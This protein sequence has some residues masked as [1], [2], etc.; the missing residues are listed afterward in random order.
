MQPMPRFKHQL[1][2]HVLRALM[3]LF[4]LLPHRAALGC[5]AGLA[6]VAHRGFGWR[7]KEA[8]RR[9]HEVLPTASKAEAREAAWISF[10][11]LWF[12][13]V[14]LIRARK[15]SD[16]HWRRHLRNQD[17]VRKLRQELSGG[18]GLIVALVH[19]GNWDLAG[20]WTSR[21]GIPGVFI[22]RS[23]KN[24]QVNG[25]MNQFREMTGAL[26]VDRDDPHL[27]R[28][29]V[30]ALKEGRMLAVLIDLRAR[31][32]G[33]NLPYLGGRADVGAGLAAIA[34]LS[35]APVLPVFLRRNGWLDHAWE[36]GETLRF[37]P[38]QNKEAER[39]RIM[40]DCLAWLGQRV[41]AD[42][43]QYFWYNKRWVLEP[44]VGPETTDKEPPPFSLAN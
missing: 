7:K 40:R 10:R 14:E 5:A 41:L 11:N 34:Q 3:G 16:A 29:V 22:A 27:V 13:A 32:A 26:V 42:P 25:L 20:I 17:V 1:E 8:W 33:M 38:G 43:S 44:L 37:D 4:R 21:P 9:I 24:P 12:N 28:K 35:G 39:T 36:C 19:A 31:T 2:Y 30:R 15:L 18:N 23:Q 6:W